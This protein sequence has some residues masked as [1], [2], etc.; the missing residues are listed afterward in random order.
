MSKARLIII[1]VVLEGRSQA[2]V[3][4]RY[5]MSRVLKCNHPEKGRI[6]CRRTEPPI[7]DR[8]IGGCSGGRFLALMCETVS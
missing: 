4:P 5:S 8:V 3:A 2:E 7:L 1:A 6:E